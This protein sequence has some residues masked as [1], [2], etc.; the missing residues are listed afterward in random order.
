M[1]EEA[2]L[3][4][5]LKHYTFRYRNLVTEPRFLELGNGAA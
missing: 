1:H 3:E 5:A 4:P 2:S